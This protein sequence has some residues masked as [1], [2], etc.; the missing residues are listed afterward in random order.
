MPGASHPRLDQGDVSWQQKYRNTTFI[1][2]WSKPNIC[3]WSQKQTF[4]L[5]KYP[6]THPLG[7]F[8]IFTW[9]RTSAGQESIAPCETPAKQT[10][11]VFKKSG[12]YCLAL[13]FISF[14]GILT[15]YLQ[16]LIE[17]C[18]SYHRWDQ[19]PNPS[20]FFKITEYCSYLLWVSV[21]FIHFCASDC[22]NKRPATIWYGTRLFLRFF[23][24]MFN[25]DAYVWEGQRLG[26]KMWSAGSLNLTPRSL[27][28][29]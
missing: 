21:L 9:G 5:G 18:G 16:D 27:I 28:S 29:H 23:T 8:E 3:S 22:T 6:H 13:D 19:D 11:V 10:D 26:K 14:K 25:L 15:L 12:L 24:S 20:S 1:K 7:S 2:Y 4:V 17:P